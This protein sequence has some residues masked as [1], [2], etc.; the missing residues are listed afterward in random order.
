MCE[1]ARAAD[2]SLDW[3][4]TGAEPTIE[5]DARYPSRAFAR[6]LARV[7]GLPGLAIE[8]ITEVD[9]LPVDPGIPYWLSAIEAAI[10][11]PKQLPAPQRQ[12]RGRKRKP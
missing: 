11:A 3:I 6:F 10:P 5:P 2:V 1:L 12:A 8:S 7:M 4:V 9:D